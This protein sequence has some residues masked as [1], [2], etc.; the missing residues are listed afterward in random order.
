MCTQVSLLFMAICAENADDTS[1]F[2]LTGPHG[3][4]RVRAPGE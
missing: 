1:T 4:P 3:S 2:L